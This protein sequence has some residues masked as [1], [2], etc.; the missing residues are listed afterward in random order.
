MKTF[1]L[2]I[3]GLI[4]A[5]SGLLAE[6][7]IGEP[8]IRIKVN[9]ETERIVDGN[10]VR[11]PLSSPRATTRA[12]SECCMYVGAEL[13]NSI[14]EYEEQT[15]QIVDTGIRMQMSP[16]VVESNVVIKT[17]A[18]FFGN[19]TTQEMQQPQA[20]LTVQ[21]NTVAY[22]S[23]ETSGNGSPIQLGPV[24]LKDGRKLLLT[25]CAEIVTEPPEE[26]TARARMP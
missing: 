24:L 25:I 6:P 16:F 15:E 4:C 13:T 11:E 10:V 26:D 23:V 14:P 17:K 2:I 19:P 9:V 1:N 5:A 12:G 20:I 8:L 21:E 22:F 18:E 7:V 3:I